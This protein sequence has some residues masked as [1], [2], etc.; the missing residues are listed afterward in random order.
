[1]YFLTTFHYQ[2]M[3]KTRMIASGLRALREKKSDEDTSELELATY[4]IGVIAG[5]S[6]S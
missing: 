2:L 6:I 4:G 1:M 5:C 3:T